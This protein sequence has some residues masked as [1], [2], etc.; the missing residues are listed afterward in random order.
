MDPSIPYSSPMP[1]LLNGRPNDPRGGR[2]RSLFAKVLSDEQSLISLSSAKLFIEAI[3]DQL[4]QA[5]CLEKLIS[6]PKGLNT[7]QSSLHFNIFP[8]F[9]NTSATSLLQY[10]QTPE[11]QIICGGKFLQHIILRIADPPIFWNAIVKAQNTYHLSDEALQS[12]SWFLLQLIS[13]P[14]DKASAYY[15]IA[16]DALVQKALLQS[17][18]LEVRTLGQK[19]KHVIDILGVPDQFD[20]DGPGGRHDNDFTDIHRII[21]LPTPDELASTEDP[22]LRRA[23]EIGECN[24]EDRLSMHIDNQF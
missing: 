19:I 14:A 15:V 1:R 12:F 10:L 24:D 22:F 20:D 8:E 9:I 13:L 3:C 17:S 4:D 21:I 6:S 16:K 18:Q 5:Q 2:L 7:L 11:L 23:T